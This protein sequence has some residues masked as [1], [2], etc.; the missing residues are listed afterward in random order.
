MH[1]FLIFLFQ[2]PCAEVEVQN[3]QENIVKDMKNFERIS[4]TLN[5]EF[6]MFEEHRME[7]FKTNI[8]VYMKQMLEQQEEVLKMWEAYLP[9]AN[10]LTLTA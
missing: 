10:S 4:A 2:E 6:E 7:E 8:N 5:Q 1:T 3:L 9:I